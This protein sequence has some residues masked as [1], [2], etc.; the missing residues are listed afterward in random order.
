MRYILQDISPVNSLKT[1]FIDI[2][3][4]KRVKKQ[5]MF[6]RKIADFKGK[7]PENYKD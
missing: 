7:Q 4:I 3:T 5:T 6:Q 1:S 2:E